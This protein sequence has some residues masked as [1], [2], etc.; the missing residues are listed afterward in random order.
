MIIAEDTSNGIASMTLRIPKG[1]WMPR[2]R[3][4]TPVAGLLLIVALSTTA[5][6]EPGGSGKTIRTI[7]DELN[8]SLP[9]VSPRDTLRTREENADFREVFFG[10]FPWLRP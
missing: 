6:G 1:R 8:A 4:A 3:R 7:G 10:L 2:M 5:C 9:T